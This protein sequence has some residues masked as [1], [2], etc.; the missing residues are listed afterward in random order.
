M[1]THIYGV[2]SSKAYK[3]T[4]KERDTETGLDYFGARYF[5]SSMGRFLSPDWSDDPEPVPYA[6]LSNPQ[7][8]N[9]YQ[10]VGNNPLSFTDPLGHAVCMFSAATS[11]A[12]CEGESSSPSRAQRQ[13]K[14]KT[15][16]QPKP[17][18]DRRPGSKPARVIFNETSG[19][20][21]KNNQQTLHDARVGVAHTLL[22][23]SGMRH[24]PSTVSD[25]LTKSA[26]AAINRDPDAKAAWAD[27]QAALAEAQKGADTTS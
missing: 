5:G 24:P 21:S 10:Y 18:P 8:L 17:K 14:P 11:G 12:A 16:Q 27:S 1:M 9:L 2:V 25:I 22:N 13:T 26:A 3:F 20:R 6:D 15:P 7:T 19:L 4:G 23:A